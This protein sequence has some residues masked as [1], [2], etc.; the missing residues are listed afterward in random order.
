[1]IKLSKLLKEE[2]GIFK[3]KDADAYLSELIELIYK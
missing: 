2:K 3:N 1:M